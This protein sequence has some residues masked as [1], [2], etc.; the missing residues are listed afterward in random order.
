MV[1]FAPGTWMVRKSK[2]RW[3]AAKPVSGEGNVWDARL[4]WAHAPANRAPVVIM[5]DRRV[6]FDM[7]LLPR[8]CYL[9]I[10]SPHVFDAR[11]V[12]DALACRT[13][14]DV[15]NRLSQDDGCVCH[16][17]WTIARARLASVVNQT[18]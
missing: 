13:L 12:G 8:V 6:V 7:R 2:L 15:A 17:T 16:L 3:T 9:R 18:P 10:N 5:M 11:L 1:R 14:D 4:N